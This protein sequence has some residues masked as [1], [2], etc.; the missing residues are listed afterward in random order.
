MPKDISFPLTKSRKRLV[1]KSLPIIYRELS[2]K[3]E[4]G[5]EW[6]KESIS[7]LTEWLM[8]EVDEVDAEITKILIPDVQSDFNAAMTE[9]AHMIICGMMLID[10]FTELEQKAPKRYT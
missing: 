7:K 2:L 9:I 5:D 10:K 1:E 3:S 6:S 4:K 8:E